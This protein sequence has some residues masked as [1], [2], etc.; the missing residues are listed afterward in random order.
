MAT[1]GDTMAQRICGVAILGLV[2]SLGMVPSSAWGQAK[3]QVQI[4]GNLQLGPGQVQVINPDDPDSENVNIDGVFLPPDRTAKRR[5]ET[6]QEL[7]EAKRYGEAVRLL[8]SLLESSEDFFFRPDPKQQMYRSL[9]AEAA[10]LLAEMP[11]EGRESYE[12]QFGARARRALDEALEQNNFDALSEVSRRF[13]FTQ[14]GAEATLLLGRHYWDAG[15]PLAAALCLN[16]LVGRAE[17]ANFEPMLSLLL[18]ASWQQGGELDRAR[19]VL[20]ALKSTTRGKLKIGDA[21]VPLFTADGQALD[22]LANNLGVVTQAVVAAEGQWRMFRGDAQ[23]NALSEGALPLLNPRWRVRCADHPRVAEAVGQLRRLYLDQNMPAIP[24]SQPV[25]IDNTIVMRTTRTLLAIDFTTGKRIWEARSPADDSLDQLLS[26]GG[27]VNQ[28]GLPA[29]LMSAIDRRVWNDAPFGLLSSDGERVYSVEDLGFAATTGNNVRTV[30]VFNGQR[31]VVGAGAKDTNRLSALELKTEGKL[32]WEVGGPDGE[33]EPKLAGAFFLGPPLPVMGRLYA[34]CETKGQEI[35]LVALSAESG[36]LDWSQ[37]LAVVEE[38]ILSDVYRRPAGAT[39]SFADGILVCPTSAGAVVAVDVATRS[40]LWGYQYP[41]GGDDDYRRMQ[42]FRAR[43]MNNDRRASEGWCDATV[44]IADGR[45]LITPV[46]SNWLYCVRL[47]DGQLLWK[48]ERGTN[49]YVAGV[50]NGNVYLVG[51]QAMQAIKLTDGQPAWSAPVEFPGGSMPSGRG[52]MTKTSYFVPLASAEVAQV[53]LAKGEIVS[54]ARSR[55]G[56]VPGNLLCFRGEVVSQGVDY[57]ETFYQLDALKDEVANRLKV[58]RDDPQA[59]VRSGEIHFDAGNLDTAIADFRQAHQLLP[60]DVLIGELLVESLLAGLSSDFA[61]Y[62]EAIPE[63]ER[64]IVRHNHRLEFLRLLGVGAIKS[65]DYPAALDAYLKLAD[66]APAGSGDDLNAESAA[67]PGLDEVA[68]GQWVQRDAWLRAR[69]EQLRTAA[70]DDQRQKID[71]TLAAKLQEI[72]AAG[73]TEDL[74][75]WIELAGSHPAVDD[76]IEKLLTRLGGPDSLLERERLLGKLAQSVDETRQPGA[77]WR[78]VKLYEEA[79][80]PESAAI[81]YRKLIAS[82]P[83]TIVAEGKTAP[84]VLAS[85]AASSVRELL[86]EPQSWPVGFVESSDDLPKQA[87]GR[88]ALPGNR[89]QRSF[90]IP[91]NGSPGPFFENH[92]V[93]LDPRQQSLSMTDGL[94]RERLRI[95]LGELNS[96]NRNFMGFNNPQFNSVSAHGHLLMYSAGF[97]VMAFDT[98]RPPVTPAKP[99]WVQDLSESLGGVPLNMGIHQRMV[100]V[101]WGE[102]RMIAQDANGRPIGQTG[103]T[104]RHGMVVQRYRDILCLDPLTGSVR[105]QRRN[106][107]A[108]CELFGDDQT[109]IAAPVEGG[110]GWVLSAEDGTLLGQCKIPPLEQRMGNVGSKLLVWRADGGRSTVSLLDPWKNDTLWSK[111]FAANSKAALVGQ[112]VLGVYEPT[113]KF[114]LINL[115]SGEKVIS[116]KLES[117]RQLTGIYLLPY[118]DSYLLITNSPP[119]NLDPRVPIQPAPGGMNNPLINGRMYAFSAKTGAALWE[120]PLRIQ[121]HGLVQS[122][123]SELPLLFFMRSMHR[124]LRGAHQTRASI[125]A[126]DK[127]T[128]RVVYTNDELQMNIS[129]VEFE[130]NRRDATVSVMF[131]GKSM[132]F[133]CTDKPLPPPEAVEEKKKEESQGGVNG[134]VIDLFRSINDAAR[135]ISGLP[136]PLPPFD[137]V[138]EADEADDGDAAAEAVEDAIEAAKEAVE[139]AVE[140]ATAEKEMQEDDSPDAI[141]DPFEE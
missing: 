115:P 90:D 107:P 126:V 61:K 10:R 98:L 52:F 72:S 65:G 99:L 45:V 136:D 12:L 102:N 48:Q 1:Q 43:M 125:L 67:L 103:P 122:H 53:D 54:R 7:I 59:L 18:A 106:A 134:A 49:L 13:F 100:N 120:K 101:A 114:V 32:A 91:F 131:P 17:Q 25:A 11:A 20:V 82:W 31:R 14:A 112:Q 19:E 35:R 129:N 139:E 2:A 27:D 76:V 28:L 36:K 132:M 118:E 64:L 69:I 141:E 62:R 119:R 39:P 46:E 40:L 78:L 68:P 97:Q 85:E 71:A 8:G 89:H 93:A 133:L 37:Q 79:K 108:G 140:E 15:R 29:D 47:V 96:R 124:N 63:V 83:D 58:N 33:D 60:D 110:E 23:R 50:H 86:E 123:P 34:I 111:E 30:V 127:R 26:N 66:M 94:G 80:R 113:G 81:V 4:R 88:K 73:K 38:G 75:R 138:D 95:A 41:R 70:P 130:G 57:L 6:G 121:N 104:T 105:W 51:R 3:I 21:E 22:W 77:L 84:E 128:G 87:I 117:E 44:T 42:M 5:L 55:R 74:R 135:K 16:R 9:K 56:S 24:S 116:E 92:S 109:I 137:E